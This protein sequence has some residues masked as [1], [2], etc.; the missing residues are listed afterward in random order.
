MRAKGFKPIVNIKPKRFYYGQCWNPNETV[1][2]KMEVNSDYL[3]S[4]V[5]WSLS[6]YPYPPQ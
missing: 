4:R 6:N 5:S 3:V 2:D 1:F